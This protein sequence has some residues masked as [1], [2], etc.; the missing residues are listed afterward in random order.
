MKPSK[1]QSHRP[2]LMDGDREM[3]L[4]K[5]HAM[6]DKVFPAKYRKGAADHKEKLWEKKDLL[7]EALHEN[8]D[9]FAYIVSEILRRKEYEKQVKAL[10]EVANTILLNADKR[11]FD[12]G[13]LPLLRATLAP[14]SNKSKKGND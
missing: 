8:L 13:T 6:F 1:S 11:F 4:T 2:N 14:F 3:H 7:D 9:Q 12:Y 5:L 10:V